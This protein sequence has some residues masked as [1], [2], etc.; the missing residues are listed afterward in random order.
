MRPS[1]EQVEALTQE[2]VG[3]LPVEVVHFLVPFIRNP[4]FVGREKDL[5]RLHHALS[6][7]GPVGIR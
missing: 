1:R 4:D 6:G 3:T 7:E 2:A 5:E